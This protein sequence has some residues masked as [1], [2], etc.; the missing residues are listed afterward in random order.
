MRSKSRCLEKT[1][2][3]TVYK[4]SVNADNI[5]MSVYDECEESLPKR[6]VHILKNRHKK[7]YSRI[8]CV[9]LKRVNNI[10]GRRGKYERLSYHNVVLSVL[11]CPVKRKKVFT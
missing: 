4:G 2:C 9:F 3:C 6:D 10:L 7:L 11:H 1:S 8:N 5:M